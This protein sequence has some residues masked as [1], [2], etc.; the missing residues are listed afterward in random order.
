[1][2]ETPSARGYGW[3]LQA[4]YLTQKSLSAG[5]IKE[6]VCMDQNFADFEPQTSND[7]DWSHPNINSPTDEWIETQNFRVSHSIPAF[8]QMLGELL[9]ING[10]YAVA[11]PGGGSSSKAHTFKPTD[12]TVTRQ[13]KAVTYCETTGPGWNILAPSCVAD[14]WVLKGN[15][16]GVL[17]ADFNLIG[18]GKLNLAPSTTWYPTGTPHVARRTGQHKLFNSQ[19]A[20]VVTDAGSPTTYGCRYRSFEFA[21]RKTMLDD[22]GMSPGCG[23][24][25]VAGDPTSGMVRSAHEFDKQMLDFTLQVDMAVGSPEAIAVQ[26]Q[27][28]L[29]VVMTAAGG[30]IEGAIRHQV[31]V[32]VPVAK[33]KTS[34]PTV[35]DGI[36]QFAITGKAL[37]DFATN[38]LFEVELINDVTNY[39]SAF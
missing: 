24:F 29:L 39:A 21:Y 5:A 30:I 19:V 17:T 11:T 9:Y 1:M 25:L 37:F 32:T 8:S 38:K 23:N 36:M 6:I 7:E 16:K 12:P 31:K 18:S 34:K 22:A 4:D 26:Q 10:S 35:G 13:D 33:Y 27:K 15:G 14:G 3:G 28:P 20:L 2:S